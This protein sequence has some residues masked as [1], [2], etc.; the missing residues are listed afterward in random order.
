MLP[1][2]RERTRRPMRG[3]VVILFMVENTLRG[4]WLVQV[5]YYLVPQYFSTKLIL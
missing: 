3:S 1:I 5:S 4:G 2:Y